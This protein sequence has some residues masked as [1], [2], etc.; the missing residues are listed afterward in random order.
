ME[1][2]DRTCQRRSFILE[3]NYIIRDIKKI[4]NTFSYISHFIMFI[5]Y[6]QLNS[7]ENGS[8]PYNNL[9]MNTKQKMKMKNSI[10]N[11]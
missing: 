11:Y 8:C 5:N 4:E 1:N 9:T 10:R 3:L 2:I 6:K 7:D